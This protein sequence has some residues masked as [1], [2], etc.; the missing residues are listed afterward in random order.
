[1]W[2]IVTDQGVDKLLN[3]FRKS[4]VELLLFSGHRHFV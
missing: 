4:L 3:V 2:H 1:M